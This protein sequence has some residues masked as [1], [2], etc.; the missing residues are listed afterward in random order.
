MNDAAELRAL[1]ADTAAAPDLRTVALA[2]LRGVLAAD[3]PAEHP[4]HRW[5]DEAWAA[6]GGEAWPHALDAALA[7]APPTAD[8]GAARW[9]RLTQRLQLDAAQTLA[10]SIALQ[11]DLDPAFARLVE[12]LQAPLG[13]SRP[14]LGL[15][16]AA[17]APLRRPA[18]A[19]PDVLAL[20][21]GGALQ[22]GLLERIAHDGPLATAAVQVPPSVLAALADPADLAPASPPAASQAACLHSA[23]AALRAEGGALIL[24]CVDRDEARAAAAWAAERLGRRPVWIAQPQWPAGLAAACALGDRLPVFVV[25]AVP[26]ERVAIEAPAGDALALL[27]I[28]GPDGN[29]VVDGLPALE[30]AL[31]LPPPDER[32]ARWRSH[33]LAEPDA[34]QLGE[35]LRLPLVRIDALAR[36]ARLA[37][38]GRAAGPPVAAD[39][40]IQARI[41][42]ARR[43]DGI[44]RLLD[45]EAAADALVVDTGTADALQR[46]EARLRVREALQA[47]GHAAGCGVRALFTGPSGTGKTMAAR[48]LAT[49]LGLPLVAVDLAA[50]TSKWIGETEKNLAQLLARAEGSSAVLLFDEAD[51]VFG[52]RTEVGS[53]N[54]RF[55]NNQTNYLLA[56]IERFDGIVLLT[57]NSRARIDA[58]F[59]RRLDAVI[60]FAPP[61]PSERRRLWRRYLGDALGEAERERMAG[62]IDLAGGHVAAAVLAARAQALDARR[63]LERA[64]LLAALRVEY[65]KLGRSMP[66]ELGRA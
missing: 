10:A 3:A 21:H 62:A 31:P 17:I 58:G 12:W 40:A 49:R 24:R 8:G 52:S 60:E 53:A 9:L 26:G 37:A 41:A 57:S 36:A 30:L 14:M 6:C 22:A 59:L 23:L 13:G 50:L 43:F 27:V 56:R 65:A 66:A 35:R 15:L 39:V 63:P 16:A 18:G 34:A 45:G 28:A 48:M 44:G 1:P 20:A 61:G 64:D 42:E 32:V 54:D 2:A 47:L 29:V 4:L 25:D 51:S 38:S 33:G 11:A 19:L 55:A 5:V 46:L 7:A